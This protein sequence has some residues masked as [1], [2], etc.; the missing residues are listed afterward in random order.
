MMNRQQQMREAG[1]FVGNR[2]G[3]H[4]QWNFFEGLDSAPRMRHRVEGIGPREQE[5]VYLRRFEAEVRDS[6][7]DA[8]G[9][10]Y[11]AD[12][13]LLDCGRDVI[14]F[15]YAFRR[16][17]IVEFLSAAKI[18]G[19]RVEDVSGRVQG[20]IVTACEREGAIGLAEAFRNFAD[21][22]RRDAGLLTHRCRIVRLRESFQRG[23][24]HA[25]VRGYPSLREN[26]M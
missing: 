2:S 21:A 20:R 16:L 24:I 12:A 17:I 5:H 3:P 26:H 10:S 1:G 25:A 19:H 6:V 14:A 4:Y 8:T 13:N 18:A 22:I 7:I 9:G 23:R 11:D 15:G